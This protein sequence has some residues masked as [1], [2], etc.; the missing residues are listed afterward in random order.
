MRTVGQRAM[1]LAFAPP[2]S[3]FALAAAAAAALP[4]NTSHH[5][6]KARAPKRYNE[7]EHNN[8]EDRPAARRNRDQYRRQHQADRH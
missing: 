2:D 7:A 3:L 5:V 1:A 4:A 6:G 8:P